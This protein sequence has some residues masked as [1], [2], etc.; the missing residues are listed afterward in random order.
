MPKKTREIVV[1]CA[2]K[3]HRVRLARGIRFWRKARCP[4]CRSPVDPSRVRRILR[5]FTNLAQPASSSPIHRGIWLGCIVYLALVF[6]SALV[7]W[8]LSDRWWPATV[9]LFGPRWVLSLPLLGL[10]PAA[11]LWDR[12]FLPLLAVAGLVL[13]GPVMGFR[14]GWRSLLANDDPQRDI[15]VVSFNARGGETLFLNPGNLMADWEVDVAAIQECGRSLAEGLHQLPGWYVDSRIGL[16]LVSRFEIAEVVEMDRDA[17]EFAGGSGL[18]VTYSLDPSGSPFYVTN[19]HLETPRA[20]FELIRAGRMREG[21]SKT[22]EKSLLRDV[23]LRRTRRWV[24][25][26]QGPHLV[27]GDFNTTPESRSYR[28]SWRGWQNTFSK[29]GRGLGGTRLNGWIRARIDHVLADPSWTVVRAWLAEDVGSDH[30]PIMA[31]LRLR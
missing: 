10:V 7:L 18:V 1:P 22:R 29:I 13:A 28:A 2:G 17:F 26:F 14:S 3:G 9:L 11:I 31:K 8:G 16:C 20:G 5:W 21:I 23:E 27:L 12:P 30:L 25:R 24:D 15:R 6:L 4:V 19:I